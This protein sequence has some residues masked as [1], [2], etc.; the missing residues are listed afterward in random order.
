MARSVWSG[1]HHQ[2]GGKPHRDKTA[3]TIARVSKLTA[4]SSW[5]IIL[6]ISK[7]C[8]DS[9]TRNSSS[10]Q[11][12]IFRSQIH[13]RSIMCLMLQL[14][15]FSTV[16]L[17]YFLYS[18]SSSGGEPTPPSSTGAK[19]PFEPPAQTKLTL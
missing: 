2:V 8:R 13:R 5:V 4:H 14:T 16:R 10:N 1:P 9:L 7:S 17:E 12:S 15:G 19:H 3:D 11:I 6:A 18:M